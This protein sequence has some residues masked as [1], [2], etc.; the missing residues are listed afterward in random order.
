MLSNQLVVEL[1]RAITKKNLFFWISIIVLLPTVRFYMVKEGYQFYEPIEVFH[2]TV[3]GIIP[4]LFPVIAIIIYLP[5]F[6]QEQRN[7]FITYTRTR[8]P[9]HIYITSKGLV[10]AL[11]TGIVTFLL[12]FLPFLFIVYFEQKLGIIHYS[13]SNEHMRIPAVTFSQ[14]LSHGALTYGLIYSSWVAVNG[15]VYSTIAFMLLLNVSNPFIA[16]SIPF[17]FYHILNFVTGLFHV[18]IF[19]PLST[20]FPFN[21]EQQP[22]W[23]VLVP[24][25][26]LLIVLAIVFVFS[27]RNENEWMI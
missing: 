20:I 18:A 25:S 10:N 3:S 6:L 11:L 16:L 1:K 19:S 5:S 26:F 21:I 17:L 9:L 13:P 24:F 4:L 8:V 14:F 12:I 27:I 15:I 23:T 2:E 7:K 22:L